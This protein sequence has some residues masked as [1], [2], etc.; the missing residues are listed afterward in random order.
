MNLTE[1]YARLGLGPLSNLSMAEGATIKEAS[2]PRIISYANEGLRALYSRFQILEKYMAVRL[3]EGVV[4]YPLLPENASTQDPEG[5]ILDTAE[6]PYTGDLV[7]ILRASDGSRN[8]LPLN[9]NESPLSIYTPEPSLLLVPFEAAGS[10]IYLSYQAM[11]AD[12]PLDGSVTDIELPRVLED[13]LVAYIAHA[14][15]RDMNTETSMFRSQEHLGRYE[16]ICGR[17]EEKDLLGLTT[18]GQEEKFEARGFC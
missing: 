11:P 9:S 13:A 4:R 10:V 17:N 5:F 8:D 12:L 15:Y 16:M 14:V 7:R 6:E 18:A 2:Q 1:L 3:Q